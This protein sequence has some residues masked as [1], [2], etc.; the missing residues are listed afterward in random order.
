MGYL[1]MN[2][3]WRA[4]A[5]DFV[6]NVMRIH[7][8]ELNNGINRLETSIERLEN[9]IQEIERIVIQRRGD[10]L[11]DEIRETLTEILGKKFSL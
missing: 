2:S 5:L 9:V 3:R 8:K 6:I 7:E 10:Y 1:E 4:D 11:Q